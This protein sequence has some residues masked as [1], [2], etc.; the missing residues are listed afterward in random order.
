[1]WVYRLQVA[2][3]T[4]RQLGSLPGH[5]QPVASAEAFDVSGDDVLDLPQLVLVGGFNA[6]RQHV[7]AGPHEAPTPGK[8][9]DPIGVGPFDV[10]LVGADL[11]G[12]LRVTAVNPRLMAEARE[13]LRVPAE[14]DKVTARAVGLD[15]GFGG[16]HRVVLRVFSRA[17]G[18]ASR[19]G[20]REILV[21]LSPRSCP[22]H[23][24]VL[25]RAASQARMPSG[26]VVT[27]IVLGSIESTCQ[28]SANAALISSR[29]TLCGPQSPGCRSLKHSMK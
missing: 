6:Q 9:D 18:A 17:G 4:A 3:R 27:S 8:V 28:P 7:T 24:Q 26:S 11:R 2:G 14:L 12:R 10:Y 13:L 29:V 5:L 20:V 21:W 19:A 1:M 16:R 15:V 25:V 22:A 23:A